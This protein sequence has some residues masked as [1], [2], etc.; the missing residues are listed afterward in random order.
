VTFIGDISYNLAAVFITNQ[1]HPCHFLFQVVAPVRETCSQALGT[2]VK[3]L[4][5]DG[6][7]AILN[8]LLQLLKQREWEVRHGGLLGLKYLLAVRQVRMNKCH[9]ADG[10]NVHTGFSHPILWQ[11]VDIFG[12]PTYKVCKIACKI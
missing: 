12:G 7:L 8:V 2:T 9:T 6:V 3:C 4:G 5:S 1:H 11:V 10:E